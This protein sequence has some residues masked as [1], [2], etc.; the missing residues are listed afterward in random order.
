MDK[1]AMNIKENAAQMCGERF[2]P[3]PLDWRQSNEQMQMQVEARR[4]CLRRDMYQDRQKM[5][6]LN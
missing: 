6:L 3:M 5:V 2:L 4:H 1:N